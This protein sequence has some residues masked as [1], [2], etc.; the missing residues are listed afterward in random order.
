[1][2]TIYLG[3]F[4]PKSSLILTAKCSQKLEA[5]DLSYCLNIPM[6]YIPKYMGHED[7]VVR[8]GTTLY[9]D[10]AL[11]GKFKNN[12]KLYHV[13]SASAIGA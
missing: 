6:A 4:P 11:E 7:K 10:L 13:L 1:M 2:L 8:I 12:N 3:N 5:Q 9:S